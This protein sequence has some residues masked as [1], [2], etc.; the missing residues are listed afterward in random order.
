MRRSPQR[1][2]KRE[3][4]R[5]VLNKPRKQDWLR[6]TQVQNFESR[7]VVTK[8][9]SLPVVIGLERA[10]RL[11]CAESAA[12]AVYV[13]RHADPFPRRQGFRRRDHGS[14]RLTQCGGRMK[15]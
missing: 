3:R 13:M 1:E 5:A 8:V 14:V 7:L 9:R 10:H 6:P 11:Q 2:P 12:R 4:I 15:R